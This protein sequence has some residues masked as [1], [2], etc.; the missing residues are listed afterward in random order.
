MDESV[1]GTGR[2][3]RQM[4]DA[5]KGAVF[6]SCHSGSMDYDRRLARKHGREDLRIVSPEWLT[7]D[8]W[9]G[10]SISGIVVDHATK[11]T[12][13]QIECL[14]ILFTRVRKEQS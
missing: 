2:T 1:R 3:I 11:L 8:R 5:P 12:D 10:L 13:R 14:V 9:R 4:L 7:G 6:V